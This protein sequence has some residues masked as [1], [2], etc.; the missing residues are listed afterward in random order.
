VREFFIDLRDGRRLAV[1]ET[2]DPGGVPVVFHH[3]TPG[4]RMAHNLSPTAVAGARVIVYDRPGYGGSSPNPGR[5]VGSCAE[6]VA[7]IADAM[8]VSSF[9]VFGSSGGG[10]HALACG[11]LLGDRVTHVAVVAGFAPYDDPDFDFFHGMSA[12]N[13]GEFRAG[14]TGKTELTAL[15]TEFAATARDPDFVLDEIAAE[16][17]EADRRALARPEVRRVFRQAIAASIRDGLD[18]WIDDDVAFVSLWGFDLEAIS[19]PTLLMQ[20]EHDVL[21]P[22][23]HMAY[24]ASKI[25]EARL[26]IVAHG[27]HTLFD[28]TGDVVRWIVEGAGHEGLDRMK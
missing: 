12:L 13:I 25:P 10:P 20:G 24:L 28:E 9:A 5:S 27:G 17:S 8:G 18:G 7:A 16:L 19:Q 3:G 4:N 14:A 2:G 6:D 23:D 21:V 15:L 22:R 26:E 11:A 1:A